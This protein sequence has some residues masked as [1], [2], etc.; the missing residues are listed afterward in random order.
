MV[1]IK[2]V[3]G[4][5]YSGTVAKTGVYANWKGIQYRR[6]H[7]IP[8][9]PKTAKQTTVR[10]SFTDA[11]SHWKTVFNNLQKLAY[12]YLA[13]GKAES[14]FNLF[15]ARWQTNAGTVRTADPSFGYKAVGSLLTLEND[16]TVGAVAEATLT[17]PGSNIVSIDNAVP[18]SGVA[19]G[20]AD[21]TTGTGAKAWIDLYVGQIRRVSAPANNYYLTYKVGGN[22]II[23][24]PL[25][26]NS[27]GLAQAKHFPIDYGTCEL[28]D[29]AT[30]PTVVH[31]A[32]AVLA[33][34]VDIEAGKIHTTY[35]S[36]GTTFTTGSKVKYTTVAYI[37]NAKVAAKKANSSFVAFSGYTD[38]KGRVGLALT[39]DDGPYDVTISATGFV[40]VSRTNQPAAQAAVSESVI[41]TTS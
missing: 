22:Q 12:K 20:V 36:G 40:L 32:A 30:A 24:E 38:S 39:G 4:D 35:T 41:L 10:G 17:L 9:N 25:T 18:S 29:K 37:A 11:V 2:N 34:E 6:K 19:G 8:H 14:G 21:G 33:G 16:I 1:K 31:D 27:N 26:F 3:F 15:L 13:A 28:V 7:V 23:G 5:T